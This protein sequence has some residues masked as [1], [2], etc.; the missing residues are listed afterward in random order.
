V[1][2]E[3]DVLEKPD[4]VIRWSLE[5]AFRILH[6]QVDGTEALRVTTVVDDD[7]V[8]PPAPMDLGEQKKLDRLPHLPGATLGVQYECPSG[9]FGHVSFMISFVDGRVDAMELGRIAAPDVLVEVPYLALAEV[10]RG[11]I[12]IYEAIDRGRVQGDV[13]PLALLAGLL[14]SP[15][16]HAAELACGRSGLVL[17]HLGEATKSAAFAAAM[18]TVATETQPPSTHD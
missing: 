4:L 10:R 16:F 8:G 5:D 12:T 18:A 1:H 13:G 7:Y 11:D 14:D 9:P 3:A 2:W 15:E 17:A 6:R